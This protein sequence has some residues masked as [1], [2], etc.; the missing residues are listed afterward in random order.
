MRA[1]GRARAVAFHHWK[2]TA[3][4]LRRLFYS[5]YRRPRIAHRN[6]TRAPRKRNSPALIDALVSW[7]LLEV[8]S[9]LIPPSLI[10]SRVESAARR[11]MGV[12]RDA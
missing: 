10:Q 5:F 9:S 7:L 1:A 4:N 6:R 3:Q 8:C 2:I 11:A 12:G